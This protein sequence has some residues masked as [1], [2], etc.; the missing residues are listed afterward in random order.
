MLVVRRK[1]VD[2]PEAERKTAVE[3]ARREGAAA[4]ASNERRGDV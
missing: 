1:L 2:P 4:S 3:R